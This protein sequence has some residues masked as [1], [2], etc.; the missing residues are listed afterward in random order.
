[1]VNLLLP[2][3]KLFPSRSLRYVPIRPIGAPAV[4]T[5]SGR[6]AYSSMRAQRTL[7]ASHFRNTNQIP[8]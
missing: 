3:F 7:H 1:M 8:S 2:I 4:T 6:F 5:Q